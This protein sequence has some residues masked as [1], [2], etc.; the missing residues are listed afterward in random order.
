[1]IPPN[2]REAYKLRVDVH[3]RLEGRLGRTTAR[4]VL[5]VWRAL[6]RAHNLLR[7]SDVF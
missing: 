2:Q 1:M 7:K 5:G 3:S 4:G 6:T